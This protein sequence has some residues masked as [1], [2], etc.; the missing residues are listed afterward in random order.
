MPGMQGLTII[1]ASA[2]EARFRSAL[3]VAGANAALD[4][5]TRLFLQGAAASLLKP[6]SVELDEG[7]GGVPTIAQLLEEAL[8]LGASITVCQSGLA[9]AG[10]RAD[11]LPEG[12][13]T[14]GLVELLA[15]GRTHQLLM[16]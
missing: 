8:A 4:R 9:L 3:E 2:D 10:M 13:D 6:T 12:I 15:S 14:G 1:V 7:T 16:A 5:T 11:Q